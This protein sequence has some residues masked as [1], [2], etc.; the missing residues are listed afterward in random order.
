MKQYFINLKRDLSKKQH[1][2]TMFP[3]A[4]RIEGVDG[5]LLDKNSILP[6]VANREW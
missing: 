2:E 3:N 4:E 1:M 5:A 6:F